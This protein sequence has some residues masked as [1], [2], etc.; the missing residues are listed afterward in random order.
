MTEKDSLDEV[1]D[2]LDEAE[3]ASQKFSE[4]KGETEE[5]KYEL[6]ENVQELE[7]EEQ[8]STTKA[9]H[10]LQL[11]DDAQYGKA[12]QEIKEAYEKQGLE[13]DAEEKNIFA[14]KFTE[15]YGQ[16]Q[17]DTER[18][19]NT[20]LE[21]RNSVDRD[22]LITFLYGKHSQFTKTELRNVFDAL[23]KIS[24]TGFSVDDQARVLAAFDSNLTITTTRKILQEIQKEAEQE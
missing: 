1:L 23:D 13:F 21:L 6:A 12:R 3:E 11:I 8:I 24:K 5:A 15:T 7:E 16:L 14:E 10:I 17:S 4:W 20:L 19:R 18:I 2:S 22:Q 9:D